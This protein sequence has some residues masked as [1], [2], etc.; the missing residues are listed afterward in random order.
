MENYNWF[1]G[2]DVSKGKLDITLLQGSEKAM[3]QEIG[4]DMESLALLH[5]TLRAT[6]GFNWD[7][8]LVCVEHTGIYNAHLLAIVQKHKWHLCLESAI[9]IKQSGGLQRGKNDKVDSYRI[10]LYAYKNVKFLRLWE[11]RRTVLV[12][13][14]KLSG[15]RHRLI[16]AKNQLTT[17]L[18]EDKAFLG[19]DIGK[20]IEKCCEKSVDAL[21]ADIKRTE[22]RI[23]EVIEK[24]ETLKKLF[25]IIES[26]PSVGVVLAVEVLITTNEFKNIKDPRK[27]ACYSG[28]AP[29]EHSS[30]ISVRGRTRTSKKANLYIKSILH[31]AS[32][33]S[34]RTNPEMQ[35]YYKRKV[36]EGKNKMNVLNAV[37]NKIIH[38]IFAC[39]NRN[40]PYKKDFK[41]NLVVS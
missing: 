11:P 15:L 21:E 13:L 29:F 36:D 7:K 14:Q 18:K 6:E 4:N 22:K 34:I 39:V 27:Y 24:D 23:K 17:S 25:A 38:R 5:K 28:V 2:I 10:A 35:A 41:N 40:E 12:E 30:G 32:L 9:Q 1:M 8:C 26:V 16:I 20:D 19:K 33:V 37:K 3:Y 31:M